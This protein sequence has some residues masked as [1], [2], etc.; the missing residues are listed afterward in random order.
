MSLSIGLD[1]AVKALRAHQLE[2]DVASHNIANAQ[3][4]G[5]SR[6][7]VLLRP[8]GI[9]NADRNSRDA[10]LGRTG[11]GVDASDVRRMR[12]LFLDFQARQTLGAKG[13]YS[14]YSAPL[15]Q[16]EAVFNDPSNDGI[17]SL[18]GK[19]WSAWHDVVN[20]PESSAARTALAHST[21]TLTSRLQRAHADLTQQRTDLNVRVSTI[22]GQI[23][24]ASAE[25]ATLNLQIKQVELN[26]NPA[27]DLRDRRDLL[28]DQLAGLANITYSEQAD[29]TVTVY[30]GNHELVT[31]STAR[32]VAAVP[33][34]ANP[35]MTKVVFTGDGTD[36]TTTSGELRGV[37]DARDVQFPGLIA[38]LNTLAKGLI[39]SIN[40][41]HQM[42][43]GLDNSTG[44][45]FFTGT[46]ASDIAINAALAANPA[47]IAASTGLGQP[48]NGGQALAIANLQL[49]VSMIAGTSAANL[50]VGDSLSAGNTASGVTIARALQPG[51]YFMT[52]NGAN[53]DLRYGSATGPIVGTATLAAMAPGSGAI[54][55]VNGANPVATIQVTTSAGYTAAAQQA[56]LLA[57]GNNT[58]QI[59]NSADA[60]YANLVSDLGAEVNS[61]KGLTDSSSLLNTHLEQLRQSTSGVNLDEEVSNM[62]AAQRAYQAAARCITTIDDMLDTL[63]NR[64]GMVGR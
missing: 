17:S 50:A 40:S 15:S 18:M 25:V 21:T 14:A 27:N 30:L 51:T 47:K 54:T 52:A 31:A 19:F 55:F 44:T 1:T 56:D 34:A 12:D 53:L 45:A 35:G 9:T 37:L 5:F 59:E 43:Y 29:K 62:N 11:M 26:G 23:N 22:A 57:P 64:T 41:V 24:A 6:Q 42:G 13:Q 3:S 10:L 48:G 2:V 8:I 16:A 60:F 7:R 63:I 39:G 38:R 49:A 46:D 36:A 33:D 61:A 58:L 28:L 4:P 20:D 32:D